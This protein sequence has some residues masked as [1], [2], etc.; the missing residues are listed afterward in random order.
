MKPA[1]APRFSLILPTGNRDRG[2]GNGVVG[3]QWALAFQQETRLTIRDERQSRASLICR[4]CG[5]AWAAARGLFRRVDSLVTYNL[6]ASGI[7]AIIA[8]VSPDARMGWR[9]RGKHQRCAARPAREFMPVISPGFR[10]GSGE[11]G[12]IAGRCR[13]WRR[14]SALIATRTIMA[15]CS[16]FPSSTISISRAQIHYSR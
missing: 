15:R 9:V 6:G 3:Y 11:R 8:A 10:D 13:R 14:R 12:E 4:G 16:I 7:F 1:F 5:R 2:T